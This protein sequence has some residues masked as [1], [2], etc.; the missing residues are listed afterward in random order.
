MIRLL[1]HFSSHY[2]KA[3]IVLVI[4]RGLWDSPQPTLNTKYMQKYTLVVACPDLQPLNEATDT[5]DWSIVCD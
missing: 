2:W 5:P 3:D 1:I 4:R